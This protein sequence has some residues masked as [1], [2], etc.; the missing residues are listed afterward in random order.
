MAE[1]D[2]ETC[3]EAL[4]SELDATDLRRCDDVASHADHEEITEALI[5]DD[6]GWPSRV[7]ATE[8]D[9]ERL[10]PRRRVATPAVAQHRFKAPEVRREPSV[11]FLQTRERFMRA[12]HCG[13]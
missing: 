12:D 11:A 7:G 8:D 6:L 10:L 1:H 5:E 4:G 3:M 9:C 13:H 2:D